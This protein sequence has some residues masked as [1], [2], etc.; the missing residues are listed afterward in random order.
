M[1]AVISDI[2][3]NLE[4]LEAVLDDARRERVD[5]VVCLGDIVGYGADPNACMDRVWEAAKA[6]VL[7]N[8]D[9]AACDLREA[10]NFNEVA[11]DYNTRLAK[12]PTNLF[13]RL[14]GWHFQQRPYFEAAAGAETAPKVDFSNR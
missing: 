11:R 3:G 10:E 12:F 1:I 4:A 5:G 14:L 2:H 8:H 7:G 9:A 6:R 13:A